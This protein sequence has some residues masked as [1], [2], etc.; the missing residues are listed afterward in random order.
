M[1][2]SAL[3]AGLAVVLGFLC[4]I[5]GATCI[6][7]ASG[8]ENVLLQRTVSSH[9]ETA[10]GPQPWNWFKPGYYRQKKSRCVEDVEAIQKEW[11]E[12]ILDISASYRDD[13]QSSD[14]V[15]LAEDAINHLY[16]YD[17]D[18]VLFKPTLAVEEPF[19]PTFIGALSYFV[20]YNA[21]Q[22]RGGFP[23]DTGFAIAAGDTFSKVLFFNDLVSC[24]GDL[25]LAQGYYYFKNFQSGI[26]TGVEYSFVYKKFAGKWKILVHHSSLPAP[27]PTEPANANLVQKVAEEESGLILSSIPILSKDRNRFC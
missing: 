17:V 21:T 4:K 6:D 16:G 18:E 10:L 27:V 25:A 26:E 20:G 1:N 23:E 3:F 2:K 13:P 7:C 8:E 22:N 15:Q 12:A 9:N 24:E 5:A 11:K 14:Y 19:R